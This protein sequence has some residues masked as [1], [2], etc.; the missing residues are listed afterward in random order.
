MRKTKRAAAG[1]LAGTMVLSLAACGG[2][3][4][5]QATTA[6]QTT[7]AETTEAQTTA[8]E[9]E[10]E[11]GGA[12]G[13]YEGT[14]KGFGGDVTAKVT[15]D[16]N[17][18]IT[19][20]EV[21]GDGETP[22]VGGAAIDPM[23]EAI[24]AAGS[25]EVDVVSGATITS[26]AVIDAVK[27]ALIQ[28]GVL[29]AS[30]GEIHYTPGTYTG[31]ADGRGGLMTVEVTVSDSAIESIKVTDH[32]ETV[33]ISELPMEQIPKDII[34]Y[35]SLGVDMIAGATLTSYGVVNAVADALSKAGG[36]V[37]ALRKVAVEKEIPAAEDMTTQVVVAGGG[38]AG[39][40]AAIG[41]AH[42]GADVVLLEKLPFLGGSLFLAGGGFATVDSEV[43]EA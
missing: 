6:A 41:A 18:V 31:T 30:T 1:F 33:G 10:A 36:D 14:A 34:Q 37:D 7:A 8:E 42:D 23:V 32:V 13:T 26:Q 40:M 22:S 5:A 25:A 15:V 17:G 21:T 12:A 35:Q 3:N 2:S 28:A 11:A 4:S 39:L 9:T 29:E 16:E 24:L 19:D 38:M 20:L 43:I 27:D